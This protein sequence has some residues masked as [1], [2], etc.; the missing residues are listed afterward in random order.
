ML[1][2]PRSILSSSL[3]TGMKTI[4]TTAQRLGPQAAIGDYPSLARSLRMFLVIT[5]LDYCNAILTGIAK[6]SLRR[7]P[8]YPNMVAH[9]MYNTRQFC[10]LSSH[11]R[12]P[13][14]I[15]YRTGN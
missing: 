2:K 10:H 8:A 12:P 4:A 9:L 13:S 11:L 5:R 6:Y 14:M 7:F 15:G 3:S 1:F